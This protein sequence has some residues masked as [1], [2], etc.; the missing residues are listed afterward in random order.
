[1][2]TLPISYFVGGQMWLERYP[3]EKGVTDMYARHS[4]WQRCPEAKLHRLRE[5]GLW[6]VSAWMEF[7]AKS[8]PFALWLMQY[9]Y[10]CGSL[11]SSQ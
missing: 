2:G 9:R 11:S 5:D 4:T 1:M 8:T 6:L 3:Q 10:L 7:L